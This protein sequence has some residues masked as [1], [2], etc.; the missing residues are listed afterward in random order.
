MCDGKLS[1]CDVC[2]KLGG[3]SRRAEWKD[4]NHCWHH[5]QKVKASFCCQWKLK[6]QEIMNGILNFRLFH[7]IWFGLWYN[8]L[9]LFADWFIR[10]DG[11]MMDSFDLLIDSEKILIVWRYPFFLA[12]IWDRSQDR[13]NIEQPTRQN[14]EEQQYRSIIV[15]VSF[16]H[17]VAW[18]G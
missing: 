11:L 17:S 1:K 8:V 12:R 10:F 4:G 3:S 6:M 7:Q 18:E 2:N 16:G 9:Y 14:I 15:V 5:S 13:R